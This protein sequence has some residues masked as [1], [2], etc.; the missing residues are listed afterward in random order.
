MVAADV[1]ELCALID[2]SASAVDCGCVS[3]LC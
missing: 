3:Q 1:P 2:A